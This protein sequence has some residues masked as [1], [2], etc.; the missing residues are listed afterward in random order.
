MLEANTIANSAMLERLKGEFK[1]TSCAIEM[2]E[3]YGMAVGKEVFETVLWVGRFYQQWF[4]NN[5]LPVE[6][7]YRRQIKLHHCQSA[8]AKDTNIRQ[9]LMDKYGPPGVK[10]APGVTYGL[11]KHEWSAFA[12]ATFMTERLLQANERALDLTAGTAPVT[13]SLV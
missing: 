2:V 13:Q 8:R 11:V 6:L 1:D 3:S 4:I 9:A 5:D 10:K 12:I 7:I